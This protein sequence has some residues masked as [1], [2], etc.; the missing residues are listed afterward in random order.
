MRA[1]SGVVCDGEG[2]CAIAGGGRGEGDIECARGSGSDARATGGSFGKVTSDSHIGN[3]EWTIAGV[4][5]SDGLLGS[6]TWLTALRG[7]ATRPNWYRAKI[8]QL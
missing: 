7:W 6:N 4:V 8:A 2:S 5:Q 1:A 3:G